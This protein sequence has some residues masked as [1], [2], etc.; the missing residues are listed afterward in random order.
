MK[1]F[2][3]IVAHTIQLNLRAGKIKTSILYLPLNLRKDGLTK[4]HFVHFLTTTADQKL[5]DTMAVITGNVRAGNVLI[6]G[7]QL[8]HQVFRLQEIQYAINRHWGYRIASFQ[9]ADINQLI[10]RKRPVRLK[11]PGQDLLALIG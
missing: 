4:F 8:M 3:A 10:G 11:Q 9:L 2:V 6:G 1:F 5:R 7:M